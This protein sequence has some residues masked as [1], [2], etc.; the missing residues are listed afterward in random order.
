M[1]QQAKISNCRYV[2]GV[3]HFVS[4]RDDRNFYNKGLLQ[5]AH[6]YKYSETCLKDANK[7]MPILDSNL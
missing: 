6:K 3:L 1:Q 4:D 2:H 5:T 7:S